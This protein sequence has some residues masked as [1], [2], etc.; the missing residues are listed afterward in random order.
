MHKTTKAALISAFIFPGL[1][2]FYLKSK[3][4][5]TVFTLLCAACLYVL[6]T[7]ALNVASDLSDRILSGDIPLSIS[8]L[9]AEISLQLGASE[10]ANIAGLVFLSC[11]GIAI[12]DSIIVGR[13]SAL[14]NKS[15]SPRS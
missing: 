1:G 4:R 13:K 5:G 10:S 2:H 12:V 7:Y 3:L 15:H 9:M 8:S 14:L 11:W 6:I